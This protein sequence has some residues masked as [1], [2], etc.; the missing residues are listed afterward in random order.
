MPYPTISSISTSTL[1]PSAGNSAGAGTPNVPTGS[2]NDLF[3]QLKQFSWNGVAVPVV[4]FTLEI[5]QD[6]VIHKFADRD[7]AY[8]E[9]TGRHPVQITAR[10][11]FLNNIY[12]APTETWPQGNLY[13]FQ[14]R[15]FIKECL[16]GTSGVLQHPELGALNCKI[17]LASTTW[18]AHTRDGVWVHATWIESDDTQADQL[19]TDLSGPSPLASLTWSAIDLDQNMGA[20]QAAVSAQQNPIPPLQFSFS[21]LASQ[22]SGVIDTTT[23]L[24]K[25][26]QG[27]VDNVIFQANQVETSLRLAANANAC[28]WPIF[29]SAESLKSVAFQLKARPVIGTGNGAGGVLTAYVT[30][31]DATIAQIA[32]QLGADVASVIQLNAALVGTPVVPAG[33]SVLYYKS[34]A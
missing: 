29:N 4:E 22:I 11:P 12:R 25:Q 20:L 26:F 8:V 19:G 3:A 31:K 34:A 16:S 13:P 9:G 7:G 32:G 23:L 10:I 28:N 17:D 1:P 14:W 33:T 24:D 5:R 18:G 21:Q 2:V 6:L 30:Q 15:Q 27:M